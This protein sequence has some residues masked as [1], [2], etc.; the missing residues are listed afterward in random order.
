MRALMRFA[1]GDDRAAI[2]DAVR[3]EEL[4]RDSRDFQMLLPALAVRLRVELALG[5][6]ERATALAD[7]LLALPPRHAARP[8]AVELAWAAEQLGCVAQVREWVQAIAYESRWSDAALAIV[9]GDLEAAA[10]VFHAIESLPDEADARLRAARKLVAE[11]NTA[12]A[13]E[14]LQRSLAFWR[15]VGATRYIREGEALLAMTA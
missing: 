14:Q 11:D 13:D 3:A 9:D 12:A 1:Q 5:S 8:A 7:E 4:A 6:L 2:S 10:E 15:S